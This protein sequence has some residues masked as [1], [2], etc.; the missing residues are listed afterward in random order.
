LATG[1]PS[2]QRWTE[3]RA[4]A[5]E[6][7]AVFSPRRDPNGDWPLAAT[8]WGGGRRGSVDDVAVKYS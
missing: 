1:R 7:D 3:S 6:S 2:W 8:G 4:A 5:A